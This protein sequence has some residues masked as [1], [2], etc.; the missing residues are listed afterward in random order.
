[1]R[2]PL[3]RVITLS[4]DSWAVFF[5]IVLENPACWKSKIRWS[6][7]ELREK[8]NRCLN[9]EEM[10]VEKNQKWPSPGSLPFLQFAPL[11]LQR[12]PAL[13][14]LPDD[15]IGISIENATVMAKL[16]L[17]WKCRSPLLGTPSEEKWFPN[18]RGMLNLKSFWNFSLCH[19]TRWMVWVFPKLLEI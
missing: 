16:L 13:M 11:C 10:E 14:A 15:I 12:G 17:Y 3:E 1:M 5:V 8:E 18:K 2:L 9:W 6:S 19:E 7:K 4:V